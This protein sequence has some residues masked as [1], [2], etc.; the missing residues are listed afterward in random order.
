MNETDVINHNEEGTMV[1]RGTAHCGSPD[2]PQCAGHENHRELR[3][4]R[5]GC[6]SRDSAR[7]ACLATGEVGERS[8]GSIRGYGAD[9]AEARRQSTTV[10]WREGSGGGGG[11]A[12]PCPER[13]PRA[14]REEAT[15]RRET[16]LR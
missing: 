2:D 13:A 12:A 9:N 8:G 7:E 4:G 14:A 10:R 1:G 5:T 11:P 16:R 3:G 6:L 15:L